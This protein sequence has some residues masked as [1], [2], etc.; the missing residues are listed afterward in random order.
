M[1]ELKSKYIFCNNCKI[2]SLR[3][4]NGKERRTC[5]NCHSLAIIEVDGK[6]FLEIKEIYFNP[7]ERH[8]T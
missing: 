6:R 4:H 3:I 8:R 7:S 2:V 1:E 5:P